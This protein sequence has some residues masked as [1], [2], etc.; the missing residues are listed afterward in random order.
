MEIDVLNNLNPEQQ[1]A[2]LHENSPLLILAGAGSGKTRV[3]TH[4]IAYLIAQGKA[5]PYEILAI[6]FTNKAA[7]QMKERLAA[8]LG[9]MA[10]DMWVS[11]FHSA[12]VRILRAEIAKLGLSKYFTIYDSNDSEKLITNILKKNNALG[13]RVSPKAVAAYIS[14]AKNELKDPDQYA[15]YAKTPFEKVVAEVYREYQDELY[16]SS[17]LDFDDLIMTV[18][19]IFEL[20]P[21]ILEKYQNRFRHVLVDEYQDT[22]RAQ[23]E[24]VR[25]ISER[26]RNLC[27][28][29]DDD[30]SIYSWRGA[31]I[32]NILE[33]EKDFPDARVIKLEEN[34]RSVQNIL[35]AANEVIKNNASRK[36]KVLWTQKEDGELLSYYRARD[37]RDEAQYVLNEVIKLTTGDKEC[38]LKDIAI[39]YRT[40]AQ[41]RVF[42]ETCISCGVPYRIFGGLKFYERME[43]KDALAYLRVIS[44][45]DDNISLKRIINTP[46]RSVGQST[47]LKL[48]ELATRHKVSLYEAISK[49]ADCADFSRKTKE[50]LLKFKEMMETFKKTKHEK[51]ASQLIELV[52]EETGYRKM[53]NDGS[54]DSL[55]RLE[56]LDELI[57]AARDFEKRSDEPNLDNFLSEVA[58]MTDIDKYSEGE[59]ALVLM[60]LHNAKGLEFDTIFLTGMEEQILP[61]YMSMTNHR[62]IEEERRLCY[63]GITRAKKK[64]YLT[65]AAARSLHGQDSYNN[66][67]RFIFEIPDHLRIEEKFNA[68]TVSE[69][70]FNSGSKLDLRPGDR[71]LHQKFGIGVVLSTTSSEGDTELSVNF[72]GGQQKTLLASIAPISKIS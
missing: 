39:F 11:T 64:V 67:S 45:P 32:R 44:N 14:T 17:C 72:G 36:H 8:I 19:N 58:L 25:L 9:I 29:G 4:R 52:L 70:I 59:P 51:G 47:L 56:N 46:R 34:Y 60:T 20:F 43:I 35:S 7:N 28:V 26:Y 40:N 54:I 63:V 24:F 30:Q 10:N 6:T 66:V 16:K 21:S 71:I 33:F 18:V 68:T 57:S 69:D 15:K 53:Y 62:E 55:T 1:E 41:S 13:G 38:S 49:C 12:C 50:S 42:E 27:V 22:N 48:E 31:D 61:H 23:Y 5:L 65:N 37:E 2:V 3:L